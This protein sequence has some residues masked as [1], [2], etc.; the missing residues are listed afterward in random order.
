MKDKMSNV[1]D[2]VIDLLTKF[3]SLRDSDERLASNIWFRQIDNLNTLTAR[4][5]MDK[6]AKGELQSYESISRCRR[7]VQE[8]KP[9]LRGLKWE[10]RHKRQKKVKDE[11]KELG[12]LI[13]D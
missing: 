13:N 6:F 5:L 9:E 7:K 4:D 3:P 8:I 10:K 1:L 2:T 11:V 12:V